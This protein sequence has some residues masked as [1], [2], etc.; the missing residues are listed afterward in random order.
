M[1]RPKPYYDKMYRQQFLFCYAWEYEKFK[2]YMEKKYEQD[3]G[4]DDSCGGLTIHINENGEDVIIIFVLKQNRK[5]MCI[6][7]AHECVH[8]A[9]M[10]LEARGV[11]LKA[12]LDEPLAY[13]VSRLM[14]E[15]L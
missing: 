5:D 13:F 7:L 14:E 4:E 6:D 9:Y 8:A 1:K 10:C 2:A 11:S 12:S 15:I 3:I